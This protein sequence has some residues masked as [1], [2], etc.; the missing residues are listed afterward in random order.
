MTFPPLFL[1][2]FLRPYRIK[3]SHSA[4]SHVTPTELKSSI[5]SFIY[6]I[7]F[8]SACQICHQRNFSPGALSQV[9]FNMS[10]FSTGAFVPLQME[11]P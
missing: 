5:L 10:I 11:W 8:Q 6:D 1:K 9:F 7:S 2:G 4:M 3:T